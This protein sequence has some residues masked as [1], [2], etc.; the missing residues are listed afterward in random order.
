MDCRSQVTIWTGQMPHSVNHKEKHSLY[1]VPCSKKTS[2]KN[3]CEKLVLAL[4]VTELV[5]K[6][7]N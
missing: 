1:T 2:L 7:L 4:N 5:F 3:R 6:S